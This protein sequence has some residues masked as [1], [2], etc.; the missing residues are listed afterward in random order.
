MACV[1]LLAWHR[2][3]L[4]LEFDVRTGSEIHDAPREAVS[5]NVSEF[6]TGLFA[7]KQKASYRR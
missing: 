4:A 2:F 3:A 5:R 1:H 6:D 7:L